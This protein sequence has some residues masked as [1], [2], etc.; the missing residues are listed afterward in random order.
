MFFP[1]GL[2]CSKK[3]EVKNDKLHPILVRAYLDSHNPKYLKNKT[4][5]LWCEGEWFMVG[6]DGV[7]DVLVFAKYYIIHILL[8]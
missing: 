1:S 4:R 7:T 5:H 6:F 2:S 3:W 8:Y